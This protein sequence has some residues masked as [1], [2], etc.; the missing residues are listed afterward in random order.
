M[1][2]FKLG[3]VLQVTERNLCVLLNA[4]RLDTSL[5]ILYA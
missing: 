5:L 3:S 4:A 2:E 1:E